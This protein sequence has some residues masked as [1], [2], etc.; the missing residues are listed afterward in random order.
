MAGSGQ[1]LRLMIPLLACS[2]S[3]GTA[4]RL[5]LPSAEPPWLCDFTTWM[6]KGPGK[7]YFSNVAS[8]SNISRVSSAE[9]LELIK[10]ESECH[11]SGFES[12]G[13]YF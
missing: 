5:F 8:S 2:M 10:M 4:Q 12:E 1:Y 7:S 3:S 13:R 9:S 6:Q 11:V